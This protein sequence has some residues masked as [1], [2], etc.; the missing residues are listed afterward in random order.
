MGPLPK[1]LEVMVSYNLAEGFIDE[2]EDRFLMAEEDL[3]AVG[4]MTL[5]HNLDVSHSTIVDSYV[6]VAD[7]VDLETTD[8]ANNVPSAADPVIYPDSFY[9]FTESTQKVD[10][11]PVRDKLRDVKVA[12]WNMTK[13]D[14]LHRL[15]I[16]TKE[17]PKIVKISAHLPTDQ[18]QAVEALLREYTDMFAWTYEDLKGIPPSVAQHRIVLKKDVPPIHQAQYRMNPNYASIVKKNID[19]LLAVGFIVLVEEATWL[20]PI[21]VV[22]KKIANCVS[23]LIIGS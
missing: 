17:D 3:F 20:S 22:S 10:E 1:L 18:A 5:P 13:E 15:N 12:A 8:V 23:V 9:T 2:E 21:V 6:A 19:K 14:Q 7:N 11:T 4:T 16:G